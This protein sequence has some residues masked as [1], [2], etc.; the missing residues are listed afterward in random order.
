MNCISCRCRDRVSTFICSS[1]DHY[2]RSR[3]IRS[4]TSII[5]CP[6]YVRTR[7]R[8]RSISVIVQPILD[9]T[10][11]SAAI[12][13]H[14]DI[15]CYNV[16]NRVS[17]IFNS[18]CSRCRCSITTII[19]RGKCY[20]SSTSHTTFIRKFTIVVCPSYVRTCIRS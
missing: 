4:F 17:C 14:N 12:T 13:F 11:I 20:R 9:S 10:I 19:C 5:I 6:S 2:Y 18:K 3:T 8:S 1:E 15:S 7:V 16:Q